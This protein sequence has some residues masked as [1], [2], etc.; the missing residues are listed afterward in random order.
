MALYETVT[1]TIHTNG[2][3]RITGNGGLIFEA[4]GKYVKTEVLTDP[5]LQAPSGVVKQPKT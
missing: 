3:I 4:Q 1:V 2:I 5:Q